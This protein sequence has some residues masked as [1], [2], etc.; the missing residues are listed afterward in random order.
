[1]THSF[2][3]FEWLKIAVLAFKLQNELSRKSD[4]TIWEWSYRIVIKR[5]FFIPGDIRNELKIFVI[6]A[7]VLNLFTPNA[8]KND[9][10][11]H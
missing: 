6:D 2:V 8:Q 5:N 11:N 9:T 4:K 7:F 10:Q 1:M 3:W